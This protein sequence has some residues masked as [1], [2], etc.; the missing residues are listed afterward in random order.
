MTSPGGNVVEIRVRSVDE[1]GPGFDAAARKARE[2]AKSVEGGQGSAGQAFD[3]AEKKAGK[4]RG[5][6]ARMGEVAGGILAAEAMQGIAQRAVQMIQSTVKAASSLDESINAVSKTFGASAGVI[7]EWGE[8]N[9]ASFGLSQRAFNQMAVPLAAMLKNS[10]MSLSEVSEQVI[11]LTQRAADMG[12]VFDTDVVQV[13]GAIQAGLR[14]EADPLERFGVQLSA[15]AVDA[16]AL[17]DSGKTATAELTAQEKALARLNIIYDQTASTAGDFTDTSDGLAN[18][19]RI[20]AAQM[21]DAQ[22]KIGTAFMP[23]MAKAAKVSGELAETFA[24]LPQPIVLTTTAIVGL[25]AA[26]LIVVPRIAATTASLQEMGIISESTAGGISSLTR[27]VGLLGAAFAAAKLGE[28]I[29]P[30]NDGL[31]KFLVKLGLISEE[32]KETAST[33]EVVFGKG[34]LIDQWVNQAPD[35]QSAGEL[36][37][38]GMTVMEK[39]T[40]DAKQEIEELQEEV[41]NYIDKAFEVEE[42][43]D[44]VADAI[45]RLREQLKQQ[46]DEHVKGAGSLTGNTQAARDNRDMVRDLT[47][48]YEDQLKAYRAHGR[49]T[50]G[51]VKDFQRQ[52]ERMGFAREEA[53][54]YAK[55][56]AHVKDGLEDIEGTYNAKVRVQY[57]YPSGV[58][59]AKQKRHGGI[60]GAAS[61]G[62]RGGMTLVGEGGP[63]IVDLPYGSTVIPNGTSREMMRGGGG[64]GPTEL[65]LSLPPGLER[66]LVRMLMEALRIE[67][68]NVGG[69]GPNSVQRAL[70]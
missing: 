21:E 57:Q 36:I 34:G 31:D 54:K 29:E 15:A 13:L 51:V 46:R 6:L 37:A 60:S 44:A 47:R 4:L 2:L 27:V 50:D 3:S 16:R 33:F 19:Q 17:A 32:Q 61:G 67:I 40:S 23:I 1:T 8:Q 30:A 55:E 12:S 18:A 70:S 69:T 63:E 65:A 28:Q 26:A 22:A 24:S 59:E 10:G 5:T 49:S 62:N 58:L 38:D 25:G 35:A 43:D 7:E 14:G 41:D 53:R 48:K 66:G 11:K 20:A 45:S 64:W 39:K 68:R 9:A 56:L 52:L 42:A